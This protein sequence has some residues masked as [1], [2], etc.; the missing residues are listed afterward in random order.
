MS[1]LK[2]SH[3]AVQQLTS[4]LLAENKKKADTLLQNALA[5]LNRNTVSSITLTKKNING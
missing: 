3:Q 2:N 1:E 5:Q 4:K